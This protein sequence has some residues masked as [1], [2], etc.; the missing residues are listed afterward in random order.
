MLLCCSYIAVHLLPDL[1]LAQTF[2]F[3]N[4]SFQR[5]YSNFCLNIVIISKLS[6][7]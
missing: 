2:A 6:D 3:H 7:K 5:L 1:I 4:V